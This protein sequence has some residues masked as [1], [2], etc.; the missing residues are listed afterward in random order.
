[1]NILLITL[2]LTT[3]GSI[4]STESTS[5]TETTTI[6]QGDL[7]TN[8]TLVTEQTTTPERELSAEEQAAHKA[9]LEQ[10]IEQMLA[11]YPATYK[12]EQNAFNINTITA[13]NPDTS[14]SITGITTVTFHKQFNPSKP[15]SS[16]QFDPTLFV[17]W[18]TKKTTKN[19]YVESISEISPNNWLIALTALTKKN[20]APA[21]FPRA[22]FNMPKKALQV[23]I[24]VQEK[25]KD[26]IRTEL[27]AQ[28][29]R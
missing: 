29:L 22:K 2:A 18:K 20:P 4:L 10:Q 23:A 5:L 11:T 8:T 1:M 12:A 17:Q 15:L 25:S 21:A 28:M 7:L 9:H 13:T 27:R 14:S 26:E 19:G 24:S 3:A 6:G 16:S